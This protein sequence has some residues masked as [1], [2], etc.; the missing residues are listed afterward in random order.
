MQGP[1]GVRV[2]RSQGLKGQGLK[3]SRSQGIKVSW[4]Q[5]LKVS[6]SQGLRVSRF[7][8]LNVSRSQGLKVSRFMWFKQSQPS[9]E[10]RLI[11]EQPTNQKLNNQQ[12]K[13]NSLKFKEEEMH[14][15][16]QSL[17]CTCTFSLTIHSPVLRNL[18]NHSIEFDQSIN[19]TLS[20]ESHESQAHF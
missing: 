12:I 9:S 18:T 2:S 8:G 11:F 17:V 19:T 5:G 6:R 1:K 3:V 4:S 16:G 14:V 20:F 13:S 7:Q 15:R 10:N